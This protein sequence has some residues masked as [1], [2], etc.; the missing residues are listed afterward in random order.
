MKIQVKIALWLL[1]VAALIA[2]PATEGRILD[3]LK[4][5]MEGGPHTGA[6]LAYTH[7]TPAQAPLP[8][9]TTPKAVTV[10][11]AQA[12]AAREGFERGLKFFQDKKYPEAWKEWL[13]AE[14]LDPNNLD[15][16]T[17]LKRLEGISPG[18]RPQ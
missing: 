14:K 3:S 10:S 12:E 11:P 16:R 4:D 18:T 17:G 7:G 13:A 8:V 15:I 6:S 5:M 9:D 2:I 1:A